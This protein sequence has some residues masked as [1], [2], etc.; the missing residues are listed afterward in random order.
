MRTKSAYREKPAEISPAVEAAIAPS[1][2]A[3]AVAVDVRPGTESEAERKYAEEVTKADETAEALRRQVEALRDSEALHRHAAEQA[4]RLQQRPLTREEKLGAWK[5]QGMPA[6]QVE[7]LE[8]N[9]QMIDYSDLAAFAANEALQAGHA[10]GSH[11]HMQAMKQLFDQH[12][13]HLQAQAQA[14]A[15][16]RAEPDMKPTPEFFQPP[17]PPKPRTPPSIVSAPVSREVPS[18]GP[19]PEFETDERRVVLSPDEKLVAK[20]SGITEVQYARNKI[21]MLRM[22]ASGEIQG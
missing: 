18:G 13:A 14:Q 2:E 22:K 11:E 1:P 10:R 5:A 21:K 8:A 15:Q 17:P 4:A 20:A 7:F 6:D 12:L 19:R 16:H 3:P 9:P